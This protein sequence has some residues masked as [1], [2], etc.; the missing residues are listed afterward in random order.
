LDHDIVT[1]NELRKFYL[2]IFE[3]FWKYFSWNT[4]NNDHKMRSVTY[5]N[6]GYKLGYEKI[7][8]E[9]LEQLQQIK[10][11]YPPHIFVELYTE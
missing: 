4:K 8:N 3:N 5:L 1:K 7:I 10:N 11:N 6:A 9:A 2:N